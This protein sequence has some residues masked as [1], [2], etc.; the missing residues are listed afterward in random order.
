M[1]ASSSMSM[2]K[3]RAPARNSR[4]SGPIVVPATVISSLAV[5]TTH[6]DEVHVFARRAEPLLDDVDSALA[7]RAAA[8]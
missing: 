4:G 5:V 7:R 3:P 6:L 8:R 1:R 2:A